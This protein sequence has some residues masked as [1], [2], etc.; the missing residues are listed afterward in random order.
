MA[1]AWVNQIF[2]AKAAKN[3]GIVRR[4]VASVRKHSSEAALKKEVKR[5]KFHMVRSGHQYVIICN[6]GQFKLIC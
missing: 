4:R 6:K 5:R 3:G 2:A 1:S